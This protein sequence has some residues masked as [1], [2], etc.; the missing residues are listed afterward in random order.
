[1]ILHWLFQG[2]PK[3]Y[4]VF[5]AIR[6]FDTLEWRVTE[7]GKEMQPG[8]GVA[9][10]VSGKAGGIY[11]MAELTTPPRHVEHFA[12]EAYWDRA[13]LTFLPQD[14]P[15][16]ELRFTA[17]L[18]DRPLLRRDLKLHPLLNSHLVLRMPNSTNFRVTEEQWQRIQELRA[19][20]T[21]N[22]AG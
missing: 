8:D 20:Q 19:E 4:R 18:L 10:W 7:L 2:N 3:Y 13:A 21:E 1:M 17:K 9:I 6:D 16:A 11:A 5:D 22:R 14:Q 12:D 15:H